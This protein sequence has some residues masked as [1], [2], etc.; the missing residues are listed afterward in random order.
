MKLRSISIVLS[1]FLVFSSGFDIQ[2]QG[3]KKK[4]KKP[5][6][7]QVPKKPK[8]SIASLTKKSE[9][10]EG[11]FEL[12]RDTTDGSVKMLITEDQLEKEYI[13]F[14][15]TENGVVFA[16]HFKG[17]FRG[18]RVF[19]IRKHYEKLEFVVLNNRYYF[20]STKVISKSKEANISHAILASAPILAKDKKKGH[21]LIDANALFLT[22]T[23]HQVKPT[24]RPGAR[25]LFSLGR[26]SKTKTKYNSLKTY[27]ENVD[28]IVDYVY[29]NPAPRMQIGGPVT[30]ARSVT[31]TLQ[32][33]IIEVP[34]NDYRPRFDDSRVGYFT[35]QM[36]DLTTEEAVNYRDLVHRWNLVKKDPDA[37]VSEPV[38]PIKYWIE[39]T[40]P[41]EY[42]ETIKNAALAWNSAF[43]K[44][45]FKNAIAIDVQP[46][47]ADWDAGDIRY[48]VIRWTSSPTPPFGGYGPSFVN[49]RT[50][51]ILGADIMIEYI[52]VTNRIRKEKLYTSNSYFAEDVLF[53]EL[54]P[55]HQDHK[56]CYASMHMHEQSI[57]GS[58]YLKAMSSSTAEI[59]DF[60][61]ESLHYLILHEMGHTLGLNHNMKSTQLHSPAEL[62]D[63]NLTQSTGL[64]GSVMDYP[65]VNL[66]PEMG[67]KVQYF[68]NKPGPYDMWAIEF[69]YSSSSDDASAEQTRLNKILARS[70]DPKLAFG[71]DA[72][73]MRFPGLS[74]IDPRVMIGDMSN[75]AITYSSQ[76]IELVQTIMDSLKSNYIEEDKSY[77]ELLG[78]YS[79]LTGEYITMAGVISR[80]IGGVYVD[81]SYPGTSENM[82]YTPVSKAD[83]KR[84]MEALKKYVFAPDAVS[85]PKELINYL[86]AQRRGFG[87][88]FRPED[89]KLHNRV[90]F[91]QRMV[92]MH[93]LSSNVLRRLTDSEL[94]GNEY[95]VGELFRDLNSAIFDADMKGN[96]NTFRQN[97]QIEYIKYLAAISGLSGKTT[98]DNIAKAKATTALVS[99]KSKLR[100]SQNTGNI[101]SR[102]HKKY[103]L[104]TINNYLEK[105]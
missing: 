49:P 95:S 96:V 101:D 44:A 98:H 41:I 59:S 14:T 23:M 82:P 11:L 61:K 36:S 7:T 48:N 62:L 100:V 105:K 77:Q 30:D 58:Q 28:I 38:T 69:G 60:I 86:Q 93:V 68:A 80:Y 29:D 3:R 56:A 52:F 71:N 24:Q 94:Y 63:M 79:N 31:V 75:D 43:E 83:Q 17:N 89:P 103:L 54:T 87:F 15:Y 40:T 73:D 64:I 5:N 26:L 70:G 76:R 91:T 45:G 1:L 53:S 88:F 12:Y 4:K 25:S 81:R 39:N 10:L 92:L 9:K 18:S 35:T 20:D 72:D 74:G 34:D 55:D 33:S 85:T 6:T 22:E 84:A 46:D 37:A 65:A 16:G 102:E 2:A 51:E 47:D 57:L 50:G 21:Y 90:L 67:N 32:H 66:H 78:A 19:K 97:L 13:Y 104:Q 99:I 8:K 27:P 42:R